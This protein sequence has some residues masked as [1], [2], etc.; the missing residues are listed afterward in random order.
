[1]APIDR[2]RALDPIRHEIEADRKS[3]LNAPI[4]FHRRRLVAVDAVIS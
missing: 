1:V 3:E 2:R 4:S